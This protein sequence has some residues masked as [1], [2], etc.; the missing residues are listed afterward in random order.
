[1]RL[2]GLCKLPYGRDWQWVDLA[3]VLVDRVMLSKTLIHLFDDG[4]SCVP[5]LLVVWLWQPSP[6]VYWLCSG[7]NGDDLQEAHTSGCFLALLL[8]E[9]V[10]LW[11][12]TT[13]PCLHRESSNAR[14]LIWF[15]L[16]WSHCSLPVGSLLLFPGA[17][18]ILCV[19]HETGVS[20]SPSPVEVLWSNCAGLQIQIPWG[21]LVPLLDGQIR[22]PNMGLKTFTIVGI[23]LWYNCYAV[24][25][26]PTS[27]YGI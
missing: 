26:L 4:W 17:H 6:V 20:I 5:S 16:L 8:Q 11:W 1:M 24:C 19:P 21:F 23:P 15:S 18:K 10:S 2:R 13:D 7:A 9:L 12:A 14:R 22:K 27:G 25:R 3:L